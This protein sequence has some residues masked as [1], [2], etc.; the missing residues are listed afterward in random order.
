MARLKPERVTPGPA[1]ADAYDALYRD[2]L[3][4][5]DHFGRKTDLMRRLK[6]GG[7]NQGVRSETFG[8]DPTRRGNRKIET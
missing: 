5:H 1:A 4:L 2:W 6:V 7:K 3:E 8:S